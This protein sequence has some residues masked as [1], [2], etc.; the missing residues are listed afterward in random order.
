MT[1]EEAISKS[2]I[3]L[4]EHREQLSKCLKTFPAGLE[5]W[6]YRESVVDHASLYQGDILLDIPTCFIDEDGDPVKGTSA[7]AMISNTC[8]MQDGREESILASPIV[9]IEDLVQASPETDKVEGLIRAIKSNRI[10]SYF[11]L[12]RRSA[13]PESYID[14]SKTL[15]LNSTYMN[16]VKRKQPEVCALSLSQTGFYLLLI[17]LTYFLARMELG[18]K[19][20]A[21]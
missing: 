17:K 10:F 8:D 14:F 18:S 12:P 20:D 11:Y 19:R 5:K 1:L 7:I 21:A 6:L 4:P 2:T 9:A 13:F 15:S 3:I 16:T